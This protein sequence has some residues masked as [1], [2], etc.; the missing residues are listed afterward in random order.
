M[1]EVRAAIRDAAAALA[2]EEPDPVLLER[3]AVLAQAFWR[4]PYADLGGRTCG[5]TEVPFLF[6]RGD[7]LVSGVIDLLYEE[8]DEMVR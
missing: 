4:S 1:L 2:G 7:T 5:R 6:S 8:P 3:G